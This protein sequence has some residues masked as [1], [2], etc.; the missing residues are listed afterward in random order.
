MSHTSACCCHPDKYYC[1]ADFIHLPN[2]PV[3]YIYNKLPKG[4]KFPRLIS[5]IYTLAHALLQSVIN[6]AEPSIT[7]RRPFSYWLSVLVVNAINV[8]SKL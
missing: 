2:D 8:Q 6:C 1:G 3:S 4:R 7:R 5:A